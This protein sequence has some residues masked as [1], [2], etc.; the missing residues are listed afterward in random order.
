MWEDKPHLPDTLTFL[1]NEKRFAD[2]IIF[3]WANVEINFSVAVSA[4]LGLHE[5]DQIAELVAKFLDF[6]QKKKFLSKRGLL[7]DA[8]LNL[9]ERKAISVFQEFR[10][11][12]FHD[13]RATQFG[14]NPVDKKKLMLLAIEAK[15]ASDKLRQFCVDK[16][17]PVYNQELD[18]REGNWKEEWLD[19]I[20]Q[21]NTEI[22]L[23][24]L[25]DQALQPKGNREK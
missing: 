3:A 23:A 2:L 12:I 16:N 15:N 10:N 1:Y 7:E 21:P 25:P 18:S 14:Y 24:K 11:K 17:H 13:L 19:W 20:P 8:V 4:E 22:D 6:Q 5:S 9:D